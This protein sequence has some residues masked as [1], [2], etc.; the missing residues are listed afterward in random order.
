V[1][2]DGDFTFHVTVRDIANAPVPGAAV[3]VNL[4]NCS[5]VHLCSGPCDILVVADAAGNASFQI[6]GGGICASGGATVTADGV[7]LATRA[8]ASPDQDGD[9][10]V[11]A[12]DIGI[13]NAKESLP[14]DPGADLNCDGLVSN[15]DVAIATA[16]I[17]HNCQGP[18]PTEG[19]SWGKLKAIYR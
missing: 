13:I 3:V 7:I 14:Y 4:C 6:K 9:L 8:V 11:T 16:H 2:P 12:A 15:G 19:Q 17:G 10:S 18:V 1:C 5:S